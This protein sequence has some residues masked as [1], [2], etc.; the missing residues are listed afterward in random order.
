M[1]QVLPVVGLALVLEVRAIVAAR[2]ER[3]LHVPALLAVVWV[4]AGTGLVIAIMTTLTV[5]REGVSPPAWF[6]PSIEN[7]LSLT[8]AL[9]VLNPV[10]YAF[11]AGGARWFAWLW[12]SPRN[13]AVAIRV[14]WKINGLLKKLGTTR[15]TAYDLLDDAQQR[16]RRVTAVLDAMP[17][18]PST[19]E[20]RQHRTEVLELRDEILED[21][22]EST[23]RW[24]EVVVLE[25]NITTYL[26]HAWEVV[27]SEVTESRRRGRAEILKVLTS[28]DTLGLSDAWSPKTTP[29][30]SDVPNPDDGGFFGPDAVSLTA[31]EEQAELID[32]Q[33][34]PYIV[35]AVED[36][37]RPGDS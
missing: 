17:A 29:P 8:L 12:F 26:N 2:R 31:P 18:S 21:L 9:V 16:L 27:K 23:R 3:G 5:L 30:T 19:E 6:A 24:R 7:L 14:R 35:R 10:F 36:F 13:L 34:K 1:A 20:K 37:R 33:D 15:A 22:E 11:L 4:L 32:Y 25:R 28:V